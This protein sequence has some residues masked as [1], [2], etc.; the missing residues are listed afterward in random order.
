MKNNIS[1]SQIADNNSNITNSSNSSNVSIK[2]IRQETIVIS[3]IVG[4]VS[5]LI[6]SYIFSLL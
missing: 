6:A 1:G 2:K 4:F 3:F 5:S